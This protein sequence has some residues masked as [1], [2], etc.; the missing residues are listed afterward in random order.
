MANIFIQTRHPFGLVEP[1]GKPWFVIMFITFRLFS[2]VFSIVFR[3]WLGLL[4]LLIISHFWCICTH[5][6]HPMG[7]HLLHCALGN[8]C[9]TIHD[10]IRNT[11][12]TIV[13][14]VDFHVGWKQ[15]HVFL[16]TMFHSSYWQ[17]NIVLIKNGI[18]TLADIV[19]IELKANRFTSPILHNSRVCCLW[20]NSN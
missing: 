20:C 4:Y 14:D 15:L 12:V 6:I 11:F 17:I 19:I 2:L 7:I 5:P 3:T 1:F 8:K 10:A 18:Y 16:S 13:R 9:T